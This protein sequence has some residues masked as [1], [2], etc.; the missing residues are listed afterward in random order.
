MIEAFE[1]PAESSFARLITRRRFLA[2][3]GASVAGALIY[4]SEI[5]AHAIQIV[6]VTLKIAGLPAAFSNYRIVQLSDFHFREY[7]EAYFLEE[8]VRR[9]NALQP[10]LVVL[11]G[12]YVSRAPLPRS[13][14]IRCGYACA[15]LLQKNLVCAL[16]YAILG[17]HDAAVSG[18]AVADAL[19][20]HNIPILKNSAVPIERDGKR[21][22]LAGLADALWERPDPSAAMPKSAALNTEPVIL[23]CHEP[24]F[25][26]Q[27]MSYPFAAILAGHTHGGQVRIPG[28]R[29]IFLPELGK[30]YLEGYYPLV[31]GSQLYVNRG[32]G[33]VGVP[34]RL[35]CPPEI[36]VF[37]LAPKHS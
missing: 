5:A 22:W 29:P 36:T 23:L 17:N 12:D 6:P 16:R 33:T 31:N 13:F 20:S 7:T 30:K 9:T 1:A 3:A 24:D 19:V 11:T 18:P 34:F 28:L 27:M 10:D 2:L 25:V 21:I 32:I 8:V 35:F 4:S 37:T 26:D 14:A 15:E